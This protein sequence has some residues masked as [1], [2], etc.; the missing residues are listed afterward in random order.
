MNKYYLSV[1][2]IFFSSLIISNNTIA[3][4]DINTAEALKL[5]E[6]AIETLQRGDFDNSII[7]LNQA[8]RLA[9]SDVSLRR[10]LAYA[11]YLSGNASKAQEIIQP[12]INSDWADEQSYQV[13]A[14]I[15][16]ALDNKNKSKKIL[17][18]GIKKFPYSG[19]LYYNK[20]NL[21]F[22]DKKTEK[23][24]LATWTEGIKSDRFYPSNYL[25]C[26]NYYLENN[27]PLWA[28]FYAEIFINLEGNTKRSVEAKSILMKAYKQLLQNTTGGGLPE[29]KGKGKQTNTSAKFDE[30][31]HQIFG[32][33]TPALS[34]GLSTESLTMIR[35][36]III[37]WRN[38]YT[39]QYPFSLFKYHDN[40]LRNGFFDA[41]NQWLFGATDNSTLYALWIKNNSELF[42]NFE[43]WIL[44]NPLQPSEFD[45]KP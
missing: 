39:N 9:P 10:D 29:F 36:R 38:K 11:Y 4:E 2:V 40:L 17:N 18:D 42:N 33:S 27:N 16:N 20:G 25:A 31:Y 41:Y 24:A 14:A 19:L 13:A 34:L 15:E 37:E 45:P 22:A 30:W 3:Q 43:S 21:L 28:V 26:S 8:I 1:L 5:Q 44:V 35:T 7:L 12:V 23:Q 32:K 6:K